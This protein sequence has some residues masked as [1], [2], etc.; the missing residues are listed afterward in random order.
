[1]QIS[2]ENTVQINRENTVPKIDKRTLGNGG[3][4]P[5]D[6][7]SVRMSLRLGRS[8]MDRIEEKAL[9]QNCSKTEIVENCLKQFV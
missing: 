8:L 5:K 6:G 1:V 7:E 4:K 9:V 2:R 3:P